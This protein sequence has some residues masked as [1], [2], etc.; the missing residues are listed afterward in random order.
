MDENVHPLYRTELLKR[1]RTM[2]VWR[3]GMVGVPPRGTP[4]PAI[5]DWCEKHA[6]ILVTNNR[7]SMPPHLT[8]HLAQ[9]RH[10]PGI[11]VLNDKMSVNETLEELL[12]IWVASTESEYADKL[13]YLPL[14]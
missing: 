12:L 1:E 10:I 9:G 11:L 2:V 5:L 7:A 8:D 4:D 3:V 14:R 13:L 6:F